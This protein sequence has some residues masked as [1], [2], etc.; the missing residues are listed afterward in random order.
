MPSLQYVKAKGKK[1]WRIVKSVRV[2]GKPRPKPICYLGTEENILETF[3]KFRSK[4]EGSLPESNQVEN[5]QELNTPSSSPEKV[6]FGK[7][8][9][10][11]KKTEIESG[12]LVSNRT[13]KTIQWMTRSRDNWKDKCQ[14]AKAMLKV[15]SLAVKRLQKAR[16]KLKGQMNK[17]RSTIESLQEK[18]K[19]AENSINQLQA[20]LESKNEQIGDFKKN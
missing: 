2:N 12:I 6:D 5:L 8:S 15:K 16:E 10:T 19:S 13:D 17:H 7:P 1:Y 20:Q 9:S 3:T 18:L 14:K 4:S 11:N